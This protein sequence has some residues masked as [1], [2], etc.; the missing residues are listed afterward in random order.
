MVCIENAGSEKDIA[1]ANA[2]FIFMFWILTSQLQ[3]PLPKSLLFTYRSC[4]LFAPHKYVEK[5]STTLV[6][7]CK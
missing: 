3:I 6:M 1:T 7:T 4:N 2:S 5:K